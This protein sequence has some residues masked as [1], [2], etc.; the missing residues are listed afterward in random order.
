MCH[1]FCHTCIVIT[2]RIP[3]I[4]LIYNARYPVS[5]RLSGQPWISGKLSDNRISGIRNQP[6]IRIV[7]I[8]CIRPDIRTNRISGPTLSFIAAPIMN[9]F[10]GY[11]KALGMARTAEVKRDARIGTE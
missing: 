2:G 11:L 5:G 8:S 7:S 4:R 3:D 6:G 9:L 10:L 1:E